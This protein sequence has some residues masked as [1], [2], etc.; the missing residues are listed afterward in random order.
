MSKMG[1]APSLETASLAGQRVL[2]VDDDPDF[3]AIVAGTLARHGLSVTT[4]SNAEEALELSRDEPP[5]LV[6][7]DVWMPGP[8]GIQAC[9][10]FRAHAATARVPIILMSA[11]WHDERQLVRALDAGAD[12]VLAKERSFT[13][14]MARVR[15][16]LVHAA[17]RVGRPHGAA[18]AE[19]LPELLPM[20]ASCKQVRNESG[21]WETVEAYVRRVAG[22]E[23]THGICR[24]C[25]DRLYGHLPGVEPA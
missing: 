11:Q 22:V 20:C 23:V 15:S 13:E 10:L 7:M 18:E 19:D 9:E 14:L 6:L 4:A 16:A 3:R 24:D 25:R 17:V 5:A 12:D 2:V 8:S 1:G 21:E